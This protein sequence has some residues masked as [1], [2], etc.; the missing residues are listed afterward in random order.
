MEE[1]NR[2]V[3]KRSAGENRTENATSNEPKKEAN[4]RSVNP[5]QVLPLMQTAHVRAFFG[6]AARLGIDNRIDL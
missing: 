1:V 3:E 4:N 6:T 5:G 2:N